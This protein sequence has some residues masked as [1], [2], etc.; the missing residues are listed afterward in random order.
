MCNTKKFQK[1]FILVF[2][3]IM[4]TVLAGGALAAEKITI[5]HA[6]SL[7]APMAKI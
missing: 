3:V 4:L 7:S 2:A 1:Y 6:G 5:Y